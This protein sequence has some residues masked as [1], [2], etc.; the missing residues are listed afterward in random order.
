LETVQ[1]VEAGLEACWA[2]F[3][4][5]RNLANLT[6]PDVKF[7]IQSDIPETIH[8]GMMFEYRLRPLLGWPIYW[9]SEITHV[10]ENSYFCDEQRLGPYKIWHHEHFF[11]DKGNGLTEMRDLVHYRLAFEPWT[12]WIHA[13]V[14]KPRLDF[15]FDY[16]RQAV[17]RLVSSGKKRENPLAKSQGLAKKSH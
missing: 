8:E 4:D 17:E 15:I 2:F 11:K 12:A 9:L 1:I 7:E 3:S 10:R 16:R 5:P 13:L 14:V 6:P